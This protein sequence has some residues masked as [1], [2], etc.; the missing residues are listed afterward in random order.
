MNKANLYNRC[1]HQKAE[2][3]PSITREQFCEDMDAVLDRVTAENTGIILTADGKPDLV[4]CPASWFCVFLDDDF[5]LIVC[6]AVRYALGRD[7]YMPS[8][9]S[10]FVRRHMAILD[11]MTLSIITKDIQREIDF[12]PNLRQRELWVSLQDDINAELKARDEHA[13]NGGAE[14]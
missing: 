12:D 8:A 13:R 10:D 6:S 9:T 1:F 7:T 5:P 14:P 3:M 4:L 11:N 2:D